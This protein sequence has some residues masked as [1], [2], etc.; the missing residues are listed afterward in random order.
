[1]TTTIRVVA[2]T[3]ERAAM[4]TAA[5]IRS[6]IDTHDPTVH[7]HIA[8]LAS[9]LSDHTQQRLRR[10]WDTPGCTTTIIPVD[11]DRFT[12]LPT[13]SAVGATVTTGVY[14][15]LLMGDLLP[16][17]WHR[18]IYLDAD[19]ITR[20]HLTDLW[21][22]D[23]QG[24]ILAA[25]RDDY[26][27]TISSPYGLPTWHQLGLNPDLPYFNSG[28]MLV[29]LDAW[30]R[31]DIGELAAAYLR[32]TDDIRLFDQDALNAVTAGRWQ[33]LATVWNVTGYWRKP[34]RRT[35]EHRTILDDARIRHFAGYGKPWEP[36]P[37][38][39]VPD[40]DLFFTSLARTEWA[41]TKAA[42]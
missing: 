21:T 18:T 16:T 8:V 1:M 26:V 25:V 17:D 2:A 30:R 9:D 41:P 11:L 5:S 42:R 7:L 24:A 37:L 31:H 29:D 20:T 40:G 15:R 34:A 13:R 28:V 3:D 6:V 10:S 4:P 36:N 23:L 39:G 12:G 35:G 38:P 33:Q 19:T 22:L 32:Q 14:A 27:P